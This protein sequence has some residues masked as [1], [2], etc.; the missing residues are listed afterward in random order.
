MSD[1]RFR[2]IHTL[3]ALMLLAW[4]AP[5]A[6]DVRHCVLPDG[7]SVFTDRGCAEVGGTEQV[8]QRPVVG[9]VEKK[10]APGCARNLDDLLFEMNTAFAAHDAN[11]LAG[12]YHWTGMSGS[13]AYNV[14]ERLDAIVQR[15]LI[16][17]V[18][19]M[20]ED[21]PPPRH[22]PPPRRPGRGARS[23]CAWSRRWKTASRRRGRCSACR[24]ISAAGGSRAEP[25]VPASPPNGKRPR[26]EAQ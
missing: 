13:T 14:M 6:A 25:A 1:P 4:C 8:E 20:P 12:V 2:S 7:Q 5:A 21:Q 9:N 18:P 24:S 10:R 19:V 16:D 26:R 3:L 17:I 11:R 23:P 15:P 22:R